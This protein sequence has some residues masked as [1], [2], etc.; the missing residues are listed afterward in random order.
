[1]A[2][3]ES[4]KGLWFAVNALLSLLIVIA[5]SLTTYTLVTSSNNATALALMEQRLEAMAEDDEQDA[6][7][8]GT[9]TKHWR[10]HG[11]A[12]D[13]IMELRNEHDLPVSPWPDLSTGGP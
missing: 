6:R 2:N 8:D 9:D 3:G 12:R 13:R 1:M 7:Q 5:L 10:L 11:W 4:N